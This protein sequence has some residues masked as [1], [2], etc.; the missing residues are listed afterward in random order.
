MVTEVVRSMS[1][2]DTAIQTQ[3]LIIWVPSVWSSVYMHD[4]LACARL[5]IWSWIWVLFWATKDQ[6][7]K[8]LYITVCLQYISIESSHFSAC[9]CIN[10]HHMF[11]ILAL[12]TSCMYHI[13]WHILQTCRFS[14]VIL[15][16]FQFQLIKS[17]IVVNIVELPGPHS[18]STVRPIAMCK[19]TVTGLGT[20]VS[21][22]HHSC[23][24]YWLSDEAK[25]LFC[26]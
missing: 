13:R 24:H 10:T 9:A 26:H 6:N 8:N 14:A 17:H 20:R 15:V 2:S 12:H 18:A 19:L 22:F 23:I 4:L 21:T 16:Y 1:N 7:G 11:H 3:P 5:L 25:H